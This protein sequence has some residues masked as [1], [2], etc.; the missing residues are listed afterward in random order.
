VYERYFGL[1]EKPFNATPDARF[2]YANPAY[3]EAYMTLLR[4]IRERKGFIVL[5]GEVGTGKTT[6][7]RRL[8]E[9]VDPTIKVVF[10]Y[11]TTL[12]FD[13]LVEFICG[14]L[15]LPV[16]GLS[17]A[18][19][20]QALNRFLLE[21]DRQGGTVVLLLD[22]AQNLSAAALENLRLISNPETATAKLVQIVLVGQ[23]ELE[24]KLAD[25]ALSDVARCITVRHRLDRLSD[26]EVEPFID[27][28][29]RVTGRHRRDLFTDDAV[30]KLIPYVNGIPR[31]I[32]VVC[33]NALLV[34]YGIDAPRV[35]GPI[36][37]DVV[38]DLRLRSPRPA[39][40]AVSAGS[41]P[42]AG[43]LRWRLVG[44]SSAALVGGALLAGVLWNQPGLGP[45]VDW[46]TAWGRQSAESTGTTAALRSEPPAPTLVPLATPSH[47]RPSP[48]APATALTS[49]VLPVRGS[50]AHPVAPK[51][52]PIAELTSGRTVTV[53][54]GGTISEIVLQHY[55]RQSLLALDL[56]QESNPGIRD[57]DVLP[58][59]QRLRL[60]PLSLD[61]MLRRRA[62]GS[63]R[64]IVSAQ[65]A[66]L[67]AEFVEKTV[68]KHGYEV[69]ITPRKIAPDHV[70]FRVEIDKLKTRAEAVR[71]WNTARR[72]GWLDHQ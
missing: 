14:E 47:G 30:R 25:P 8:M 40:A 46:N 11:N 29:L 16:S 34:A 22:E 5:T 55:G 13:E 53:R 54:P 20:L 72:L 27:Y 65:P 31:L 67:A 52:E 61:A 35:T 60:P 70:L 4:G 1:R 9:N 42:P 3:R 33:D 44:A 57:L 24:W 38:A 17:P 21:E 19:R 26:A 63:Y 68:R 66:S 39:G 37:D 2:C 32:N 59:G 7:L 18:G 69:V 43:E 28:R 15:E 62:D 12:E 51:S 71:V 49:A 58:V 50:G 10:L 36:V 6:L 56:I 41:P 45:L 64:I 23:P 48:V